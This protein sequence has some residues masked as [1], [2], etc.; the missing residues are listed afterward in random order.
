M[1]FS[2]GALNS[3]INIQKPNETEL[4]WI[5]FPYSKLGFRL[6]KGDTMSAMTTFCDIAAM[7]M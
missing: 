6:R 5:N 4:S 7:D 2:I 3:Y 1:E